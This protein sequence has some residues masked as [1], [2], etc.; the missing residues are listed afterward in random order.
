MFIIYGCEKKQEPP[1]SKTQPF[2]PVQTPIHTPIAKP[3]VK[4]DEMPR[5]PHSNVT[6]K[7][8]RKIIV[9]PDVT[10]TWTGVRLIF[11]DRSSKKKAEFTVKLGSEMNIPGTELKVVCIEFLPDFKMERDII[12]SKSNEPHNP[13]V[14]V[15]IYEKG[16]TVFS[17]WLYAKY[18]DIHGFEHQRYG[19]ILKEG[20]RG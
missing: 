5:S 18:P 17:G 16:R 13:A 9:P 1:P 2:T 19:I 14:R 20:I 4:P 12:T 7:N 10:K 8:E 11:E 15:N 6:S 3:E